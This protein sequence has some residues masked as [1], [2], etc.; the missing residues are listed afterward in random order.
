MSHKTTPGYLAILGALLVAGC[1]SPQVDEPALS[2]DVVAGISVRAELDPQTGA[3]ILPADRL[4]Y[5][6]LEEMDLAHATAYAVAACAEERGVTFA[7]PESASDP[8]Y[9]SETYFGPWTTTQ[10]NSFGFVMPMTEADL[11][12]NGIINGTSDNTSA[13]TPNGDLSE[14]DWKVIDECNA[15]DATVQDLV[16]ALHLQ[17]PWMAELAA[18]EAAVLEDAQIQ[19]ILSELYDC[20]EESGL[21]PSNSAQPWLPV[22]ADASQISEGQIRLALEVVDCKTQMDFTQRVADRHAQLQA[23][24][25]AEYANELVAQRDRIDEALEM[26]N[27]LVAGAKG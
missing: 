19:E 24:I 4:K 8:V 6:Q 7:P 13:A 26:S 14:Q 10:A 16:A 15:T 17:G 1:A 3:V 21:S 2:E 9:R 18:V 23:P 22:G 5:D 12:A 11:A 27:D 25:I 20:Y